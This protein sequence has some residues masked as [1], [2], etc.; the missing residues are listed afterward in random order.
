MYK[1]NL[2]EME[3]SIKFKEEICKLVLKI[4]VKIVMIRSVLHVKTH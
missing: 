1:I 2:M 3:N 4:I